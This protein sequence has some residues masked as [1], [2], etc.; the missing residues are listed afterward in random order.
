MAP[1][2]DP[3]T[4]HEGIRCVAWDGRDLAKPGD[5]ETPAVLVS[6]V[7]DALKIVSDD[8]FVTGSIDREA[9]WKLVGFCIDSETSEKLGL[10]G[11]APK[12]IHRR[13][14]E[15]RSGWSIHQLPPLS[16]S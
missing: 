10:E 6:D 4:S 11:L 1:D 12:S 3:N 8:G 16:P 7:T 15:S 14:A 13:L 5:I 9:T 2:H